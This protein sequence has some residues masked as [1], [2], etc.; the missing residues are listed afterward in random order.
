V[1]LEPTK[2]FSSRVDDYARYRPSYP[3]EMMALLARECAL[4][5]GSVVAD[6]GCGTGL[7]AKLFLDFGCRVIGVEPNAEMRG[8]GDRFLSAYDKFGSVDARAERTGLED[9]S[10]DLVA[11]AQ[12]FHWFDAVAARRE[13]LRILRPPG[14]VVLI[15]NEREV[16]ERGFLRGYEDLLNRYAAEY[17]RVDHRRID[18]ERLAEFYGH[19][20]W[21]LATFSNAQQFDLTG[22][23]GRLES[24]SYSPR[25]DTPAYQPM[26]ADLEQLFASHQVNGLVPFVYETKVYYGCL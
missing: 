13:F 10:V 21:K 7:L 3:A 14:W 17:G 15:W 8:A 23:R 18:S 4:S 9:A 5:A 2:R 11:A 25:S 22:V 26:M 12:A 24:S 16:P 6:I 19:T 20:G 1:D